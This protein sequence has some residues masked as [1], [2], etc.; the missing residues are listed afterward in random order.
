MAW[1]CGKPGIWLWIGTDGVNSLRAF[2][3]PRFFLCVANGHEPA[4]GF[5]PKLGHDLFRG[6][7]DHFQIA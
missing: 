3:A 6:H 7:S 2:A 4:A 1:A 5:L